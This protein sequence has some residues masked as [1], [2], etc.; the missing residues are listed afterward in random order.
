MTS[1]EMFFRISTDGKR[2]HYPLKDFYCGADSSACW[3]IG[4]GP[5]LSE[6]PI[7]LIA[8]SPIPKFT[9]N[10]AGHGLLRPDFWTSYDSTA[11]FQKSCYL[12]PSIVKFLHYSRSTDLVPETTCKVCDAPGTM[13]FERHRENSYEAFL[14]SGMDTGERAGRIGDWQ[15]S[16]LQAIQIAYVIGFRTLYL[17]GCELF[18]RPTAEQL[19]LG[20]QRGVEYNSRELLGHFYRRCESAGVSR[21]DLLDAHGGGQYHFEESK[22][23]DST[24][25]TDYHYFRVAQYLRLARRSMSTAGLRLVSVTPNS[26]LNDDF[27]YESVSD[28]LDQIGES[29]GDWRRE[30]TQ[31][32]Y[33]ETENRGKSGIGPM[34]DFLPHYQNESLNREEN[35]GPAFPK[36]PRCP[37]ELPELAVDINESP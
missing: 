26:R 2:T 3:I 15:D 29:V 11:R 6:M 36:P 17:L 27:V 28:V 21:K 7:D 9:M 32:R 35:A 24:V 12:D 25:R 10:L 23:I 16:L 18:V 8:D 13:F 5:S 4:G 34:K 33:T 14:P 1:S 31:G 22:P 19:E 20:A 30:P 37:A